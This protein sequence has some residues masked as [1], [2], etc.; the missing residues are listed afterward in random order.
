MVV[1]TAASNSQLNTAFTAMG[2]APFEDLRLHVTQVH[3][4]YIDTNTRYEKH[5]IKGGSKWFSFFCLRC[6]K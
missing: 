1:T 4:I 2:L 6:N 3:V 5:S